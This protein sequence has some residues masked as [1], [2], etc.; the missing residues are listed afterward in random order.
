MDGRFDGAR[1]LVAALTEHAQQCPERVA[2]RFLDERGATPVTYRELDAHARAIA[3]TLLAHTTAGERAVLVYPSGPDYVAAFFGCLYAGVIAVPAYPPESRRTQHLARLFGILRDAEPQVIL[4]HGALHETLAEAFLTLETAVPTLLSTDVD[5]LASAGD[6]RPALQAPDTIAFLQYTSGSTA[7]PKGVQVS[8]GNLAANEWAIRQGFAIGADDV[9]VTWLPLYHDMGLIGGLLQALYSGIPCVLMS[10]LFFLQRP[11]RWLQAIA[12]YGGTISGGPDFAYRLCAER[13]RDSALAELD[14]SRWRVAFSGSEPI[15]P[16]TLELFAERFEPS[17]FRPASF[18]ACYGLAEATLYVSGSAPDQGIRATEFT[19]EALAEQRGVPGTGLNV[20]SCGTACPG[21]RLRVVDATSGDEV[22]AGQVGEVWTSGPSVAQGYWRN[23]EATAQSFVQH[24]GQ[25]WLRTGDLGLLHDDQLYITGRLKDMLILRGQNLY[26][27]DLERTVENALDVVRKGR[28]AAFAVP[29][30]AGEESIGIAAEVNRGLLKSLDPA[31]VARAIRDAVADTHGESPRLVVLLESGAM[32]KT[33]SGKLKRSACRQLLA[34]GQLATVF[35][36]DADYQT[37][38]AQF[39]S[40]RPLNEAEQALAECWNEVLGVTPLSVD[41]N[42]FALGGNSLKAV[43]LAGRLRERYSVEV[44][45]SALFET[46][47]LGAF[48]EGLATQS[49]VAAIPPLVA[50][51]AD[52]EQL[53]SAAQSQLWFLWK[54]DPEA[55]AYN[56]SGQV[57][58]RGHLDRVALQ[59]AFDGLVQR[60]AV[61]RTCFPE[62]AGRARPSVQPARPVAIYY[63]DL[64]SLPTDEAEATAQRLTQSAADRPFDLTADALLRV[65]VVSLAHDRHWLQLTI[66][67]IIADGWSMNRLIAEFGELYGAHCQNRTARLP[68]LAVQYA[69]VAAWQQAWLAAGEG[70]RQLSYWRQQL[71]SEHPLLPL[72]ADRP[73]PAIQG[74]EGGHISLTLEPALTASLKALASQQRA[75]LAM[76]LLSSF[77]VL[78]MRY[79][80]Q[81]DLRIGITVS[82]RNRPEVEPLIGFFVNMLV[83]RTDLSADPSFTAL[84]AQ[85]KGTLLQA[86]AHQDL[87]FEQLVEALQPERSL[88]HNPLFQVAFDHQW[89]QLTGLEQLPDLQLDAV[90]H[91]Q[92]HT[93]FDLT[94]HTLETAEELTANFTYRT[95]LFEPATVER[96][97]RH[98]HQLL[99]AII[100]QPESPVGRLPLMPTNERQALIERWNQR[101]CQSHPQRF[102]D[103]SLHRVI[104]NQ[105]RRRPQA[106]AVSCGDL[107]LTYEALDQRANAL[108]WQLREQGVGPDVLVGLALE[109]SLDLVIG[110]LAILKAGG[111]YL[112]LDPTYPAERLAY[113]RE[114]SG[115]RLLVTSRQLNST[116][117]WADGLQVLCLEDLDDQRATDAPPN[118]TLPDHLAYVIYTSGS[119]GRPKG[120]MISHRNVLRLFESAAA[121]F[122]FDDQDVWSLFHAY[123]FDF[124]VWEIF[125]AL[126]YGGRLLVVPY[127]TTREPQAFYQLLCREGVTVLNQTPSAFRGL[128]AAALA[129]DQRSAL[130]YVVFGGEALDMAMLRPWMERF[131]EQQPCLVNMYGITET[132]VHVTY[133]A[134]GHAD[135]NAIDSP[136]GQ[137]LADLDWYFLD[138]YGEPVPPGVAGELYIGGPGLARG[139]LHRGGLSAERFAASPF[140]QGQRLYRTGDLARFRDDG[141]A[142]YLGRI[143]QQVKVRGF[144]IELGEIEARLYQQPTVREAVVRVRQGTGEA[145]LIGYVVPD[146]AVLRDQREADEQ[147]QA[148]RV[149]QWSTVFDGIYALNPEGSQSNEGRGPSFTGWNDSYGDRPIPLAQM[150]EWLDTSVARIL[151]LRPQRVLEIGCGVGLL[152]QHL[153]PRCA[154]YRGTDLSARAVAELAA[155]AAGRPELAQIELSQQ[156]ATDFH[157]IEAGGYDTVVINSV[158]QYFPDVDYLMAVLEGALKVLSPGG[159]IFLGDLRTLD[160]LPVFHGSVELF[161][162]PDDLP[163]AY[164]RPRIDRSVAEDS[165]LLLA[166][167]FFERLRARLPALGEC[168]LQLRR[169][170]ADNELTRYR[171]D[172]ILQVGSPAPVRPAATQGWMATGDDLSELTRLLTDERPAQVRIEQVRNRRLAADLAILQGLEVPGLST[173]ADL[174]TWL[175]TQPPMGDDPQAYW[176]LA[177]AHGYQATLSWSPGCEGRFDVTLRDMRVLDVDHQPLLPATP[178]SDDWRSQASD[179]LLAKRRQQLGARLREALKASLPA[180]MLPAQILV[181]DRLPLTSNGK[182]DLSQLLALEPGRIASA[183]YRAPQGEVQ[184]TLASV[185]A[186]A[187]GLE[188]VG[189]DDNFFELGGHSLLATQVVARLNAELCIELSLRDFFEASDLAALAIKVAEQQALGLS[190][191]EL[192]AEISA[193]LDAIQ[194]LS[195]TQLQALIAAAEEMTS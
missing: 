19:R 156:A 109:R 105:A 8:H 166:P 66:H 45:V 119:T 42:F 193:A 121:Q 172:A 101:S 87:P 150:Q 52:A 152:T 171:Y 100:A 97:A 98:W 175:R 167:A 151:A 5:G 21:Q 13:V 103:L 165:E 25:L 54:L 44:P 99:Q 3:Q 48:A 106:V 27:Q 78:L 183:A 126:S 174:R 189:S 62:V 162:A 18:M 88:G 117:A 107:S 148:E 137:P 68:V 178:T 20:A 157:G 70:E 114:D 118:L 41:D 7:T 63:Q 147:G 169:G 144:R 173:V 77:N 55:V 47:N 85:V 190:A 73:R 139:Y 10:P 160:L 124:S 120:V 33:S 82:G 28:V 142:E 80:G 32:P 195:E 132:T 15:R 108:A 186:E 158:A 75:T 22:A 57:K 111:A 16:D 46:P 83:L 110:L 86:Q 102:A 40:D 65:N 64:A 67:H 14:L 60:H 185:W 72:P 170:D 143:D 34:D 168:T 181:L 187:L 191:G 129:S 56:I 140:G 9:I 146:L 122:R 91:F 2:L 81:Q 125:G 95:D 138:A 127:Y 24:D 49:P 130:R 136:M 133:R 79:S 26:P 155:W 17:G 164:L 192:D 163:L 149:A 154:V 92:Q 29:G 31:V 58:L 12:E 188:R 4:T 74:F 71:G 115:I 30:V 38:I 134:L 104:E 123:A 194:G 131:G 182:L 153:A 84:L 61:L 159:R 43:Q 76:L 1:G 113:M 59:A 179:P 145:Q 39:Q 35:V 50:L 53:M 116:L 37:L 93:Q 161:R 89:P 6:W 141:T 23:P 128:I 135:L 11:L 36:L 90:E 180:H 176:A 184:L 94:L 112:P 69:D 96:M 177:E 51:A